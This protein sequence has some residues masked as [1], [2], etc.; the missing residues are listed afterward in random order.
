MSCVFSA[1]SIRI[2]F[3]I[4]LEISNALMCL[5]NKVGARER[6]YLHFFRFR[7]EKV[8]YSKCI[9]TRARTNHLITENA[10]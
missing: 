4:H 9:E 6:C 1:F 10:P 8:T 3:A 2:A 5:I 7:N